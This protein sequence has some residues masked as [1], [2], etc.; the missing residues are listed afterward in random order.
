MHAIDP[1]LLFAGNIRA[2]ARAI[3]QVENEVP[4]YERLL[5]TD[6]PRPQESPLQ[7]TGITG[8]PGV[9]KST[10]INGLLQLW[11]EKGWKTAVLAVD[12]SSPFHQ[13]ALLGDRLRMSVQYNHPDLFIRSLASRGSLGGLHPKIIE[14]SA[15]IE[16]A[17]FERLII[18]TVGVG[19]SE[20]A[21][22]GLADATVVVLAPESGDDV[23]SMKAGLMEIADLFVLNKADRPGADKAARYLRALSHQKADPATAVAV[24]KTVATEGRG[25]AELITALDRHFATTARQPE[26]KAMLMA[27]KAW[28]LLAAE[29]M[30]DLSK[31]AL[32]AAIAKQ[33]A[34]G[35]FNLFRFVKAY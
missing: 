2:L 34:A 35:S 1:Q 30:R 21:I 19:Q 6:A 25:L 12:P 26:R 14:I 17:G 10:L 7:I 18:E 28:Q 23:Q 5:E 9:G 20:V 11:L 32:Q 13:G 4:G 3:S 31:P 16:K 27:E 15:L 29:R 24:V 22:A 8:P 33:L